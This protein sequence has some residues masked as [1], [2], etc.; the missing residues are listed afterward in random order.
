MGV[1]GC[2]DDDDDVRWAGCGWDYVLAA[3]GK[4]RGGGLP[5][6]FSAGPLFASLHSF[7]LGTFFSAECVRVG[8]GCFVDRSKVK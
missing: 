3:V 1:V 6:F 2:C 5:A 8:G 4:C 7:Q